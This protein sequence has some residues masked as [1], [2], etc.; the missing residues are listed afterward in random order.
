[1]LVISIQSQVVHGHVGNSAAVFPMQASGLTV[2][3]VPTTLLSNHPHY[4]TMRGQIL[5]PELIDDLLRGVV[6]R[7][8]VEKASVIVTGYLGSAANASVVADFV[9][10]ARKRNPDL[11]YVC[12]PVIGDDDIGVF[13]SDGLPEAFRERLVPMAS[14]I[15]PNQFELQL[16]SGQPVGSA[17]E[18]R[19]AADRVGAGRTVVVTG[20]TLDDT[21]HGK[22]ETICCEADGVH[23]V[24]TERLPIR[25][26]GTGD[27]FTGL[28]VAGL[29]KGL[30]AVDACEQ[31]TARVL[32]ILERT[33]DAGAEEMQLTP[34]TWR[35]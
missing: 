18:L 3:A 30:G 2:A 23:R 26:C 12:D 20:V 5:A 27:L 7:G 24:A 19:A 25:P 15:T 11:V 16:L 9:A 28:F 29:A 22:V 4:P 14:A 17:V 33:M 6:E 35:S 34:W 13:V 32:R 31:A 8:L 21:P 10:R 1:M